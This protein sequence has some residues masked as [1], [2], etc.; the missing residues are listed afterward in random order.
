M[1]KV[2]VL[3]WIFGSAYAFGSKDSFVDPMSVFDGLK[4]H[5]KPKFIY[6]ANNY[7]YVLAVPCFVKAKVN[8]SILIDKYRLGMPGWTASPEEGMDA[9][10]GLHDAVAA[11][12]WTK[13][14]ISLFGGDPSQITVMGQSA[15]AGI[16]NLMI[17][18]EGGR[19]DCPFQQ[20]SQIPF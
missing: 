17:T 8:G 19:G 6:V 14:Y 20:V 13:K 15:G 2:P 10:V 9:N 16:M 12:E 18:G 11:V 3:H 1:T 4:N 7:R 5:P